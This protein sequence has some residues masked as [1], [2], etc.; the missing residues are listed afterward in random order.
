MSNTPAGREGAN[1]ECCSPVMPY[2]TTAAKDRNALA[3]ASIV[4]GCISCIA[5]LLPP[6][7]VI[8]ALPGAL[9]GCCA[10]THAR[11]AL[12]RA[13]LLTSAIGGFLSLL[14]GILGVVIAMCPAV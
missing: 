2:A 8:F 14:N 9:L 5:W 11:R 12:V 7:G 6:A 13:G 1:A 4:L 3:A 10:R